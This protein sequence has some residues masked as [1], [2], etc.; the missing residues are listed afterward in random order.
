M[1]YQTKSKKLKIKII[2][3]A[4]KIG[5]VIIIVLCIIMTGLPM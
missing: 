1:F 5:I 4:T 3:Q 2:N